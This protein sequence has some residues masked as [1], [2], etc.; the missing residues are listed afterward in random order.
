M[1]SAL[2]GIDLRWPT[3][4]WSYALRAPFLHFILAFAAAWLP[5][6]LILITLR[7]SSATKT[8][9]LRMRRYLFWLAL[10]VA[11]VSHV[12]EDWYIG[13]F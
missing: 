11:I 4:D 8:D 7:F 2:A 13:W 5:C 1:C 12:L 3:V 6:S 9:A 10:S